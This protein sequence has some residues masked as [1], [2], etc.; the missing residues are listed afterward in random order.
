MM[1][2]SGLPGC[3]KKNQWYQSCANF[4][5]QRS[6]ASLIGTPSITTSLRTAFGWSRARRSAT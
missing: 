5:S 1:A 6:S 2:R 3:A 4:A